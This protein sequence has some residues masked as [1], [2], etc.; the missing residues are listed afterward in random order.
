MYEPQRVP[1]NRRLYEHGMC[2][3]VPVRLLTLFLENRCLKSKV[4]VYY[5]ELKK[6]LI[7][8]KFQTTP[9]S[10]YNDQIIL[11]LS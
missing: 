1:S 6:T 10:G 5:F 11:D 2:I 3:F 7:D 8:N 9:K 4:F